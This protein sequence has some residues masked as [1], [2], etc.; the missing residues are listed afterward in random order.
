MTIF[1]TVQLLER[2]LDVDEETQDLYYTL[3][4]PCPKTYKYTERSY[5]INDIEFVD[6]IDDCPE[7]S[8]VIFN[9]GHKIVV[10]ENPNELWIRINDLKNGLHDFDRS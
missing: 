4:L 9:D 3:G 2:Y 10:L 8:L 7:E 6:D 1:T 5:A